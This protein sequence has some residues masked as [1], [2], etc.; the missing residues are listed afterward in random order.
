MD[1]FT[2]TATISLVV[3]IGNIVLAS[4]VV[5]FERRNPAS[6]WAWLFVLFFIPIFG[7]VIYMFFGRNSKREKTFLEKGRFDDAVYYKY[8]SKDVHPAESIQEQQ[9]FIEN[10]TE[11]FGK[12]YLPE[13][14]YLHLSSGNWLTFN[15]QITYYNNGKEK[16]E[17][18]IRDIQAAKK[19]IHL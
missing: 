15:N 6:T 8:L 7:F 19:F 3:M 17:A 9:A 5:F 10:K 18:L 12:L 13:L 14:A 11:R 1:F 4:L 16:F 2:W